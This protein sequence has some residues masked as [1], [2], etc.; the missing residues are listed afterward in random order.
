MLSD[1]AQLG[2]RE[3]QIS[4]LDE[5]CGWFKDQQKLVNQRYDQGEIRY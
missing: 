3:D 1:V 5:M 2:T 4:A